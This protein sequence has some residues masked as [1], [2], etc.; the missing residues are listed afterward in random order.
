VGVRQSEVVRVDLVGCKPW[1][2]V[3]LRLKYLRG[4]LSGRKIS[5]ELTDAAKDLLAT[6]TFDLN[7]G[8]RP[9]KRAIQ[10]QVQDPLALQLLHAEVQSGDHIVV[11][12]D[13][14]GLRFIRGRGLRAHEG[15][16]AA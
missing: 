3:E 12:V 15:K 16:S 2:I 10:R 13:L 11:D 4:V 7:C 8:A 9:L 14:G 5:L 1:Q 6:Q